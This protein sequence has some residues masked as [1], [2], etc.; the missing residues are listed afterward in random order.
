MIYFF[1]GGAENCFIRRQKSKKRGH[2]NPASPAKGRILL[3]VLPNNQ[4]N[5][6]KLKT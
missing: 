2:F 1:T 6:K 5:K 4:K 3:V